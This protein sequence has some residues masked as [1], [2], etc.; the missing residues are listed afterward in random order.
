[1]NQQN[2]WTDSGSRSPPSDYAWEQE[3][4]DFLRRKLPDH[5]PYRVWANFEFI[6]QDG[7]INEVDALVVTSKGLYLVEIKSHPGAISG[8]AGSWV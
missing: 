2:R 7:S 1:L 8:D 5:E 6:A 4:L 3:A